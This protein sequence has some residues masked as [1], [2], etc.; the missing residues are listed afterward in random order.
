MSIAEMAKEICASKSKISGTPK[1][2]KNTI[3]NTASK[4]LGVRYMGTDGLRQYIQE[5]IEVV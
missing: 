5:L 2:P 1:Q 4:K 3:D